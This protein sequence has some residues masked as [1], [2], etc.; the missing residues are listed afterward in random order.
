MK[1]SHIYIAFS[2]IFLAFGLKAQSDLD[3]SGTWNG[4]VNVP[5]SEDLVGE[6]FFTQ[7]GLI[8]QGY[9]KLKTLDGKDST[10]Y[11]FN[12]SINDGV[13]TFKG[14]EFEYKAPGACMSVTELKL[15]TEGEQV[16][17]IGKWYGDFSFST[18]PP[19]VS[20]K[21]ELARIASPMTEPISKGDPET[22]QV[23]ENDVIGNALITEL[24]KRKYYALIIGINDYDDDGITDLDNPV[25][26]AQ[27][28]EKV[29]EDNYTFEPE[30]TQF[31]SNPTRTEIIEYSPN[32]DRNM[33]NFRVVLAVQFAGVLVDGIRSVVWRYRILFGHQ[34]FVAIHAAGTCINKFF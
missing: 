22:I 33:M 9:A 11:T 27:E 20:G 8:V 17:L 10:K 12:G 18:C 2:L 5:L 1:I 24:G 16:R 7:S 23:K 14:K 26:D 25:Y 32:R 13:I 6:Y 4:P 19:G 30:N 3:I 31:L 28:L 34:L 21:I 29:L 15:D